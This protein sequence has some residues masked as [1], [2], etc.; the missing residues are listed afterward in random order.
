MRGRIDV[1]GG[2]PGK[3]VVIGTVTIR[4]GWDVPANAMQL[5]R[6][7]A[8]RPPVER[9]IDTVRLRDPADATERRAVTVS[10]EVRVPPSSRVMTVSDSGA[11]TIRDVAGPV[12]VR[13]QS[14]AIELDRLGGSTEVITGSGAV[15]VDDILGALIVETGSGGFEGRALGS[16][17]R[18]RTRS[19]QIDAGLAND[20]DVHVETASSSV[21]LQGVRGALTVVTQSGRVTI[22]GAPGDEWNVNTGS[23]SVHLAIEPG[24]GFAVQATNRSGSINVEGATVQGSVTKRTVT[25]TV[26]GGGPAVHVTSRSGSIRFTTE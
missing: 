15:A 12:S 4:V 1:R 2:E 26:S 24:R 7:V 9:D 23:G 18:I 22:Q 16:D 10:Y 5:A 14:A 8:D 3:V 19:G 17:V 20:G 6:G 11:T 25:G 21:Q 13:T